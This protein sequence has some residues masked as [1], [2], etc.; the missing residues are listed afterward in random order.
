[1]EW[2]TKPRI[3]QP[4]REWA[5]PTLPETK[6]KRVLADPPL[7]LSYVLSQTASGSDPAAAEKAEG[8]Q[9]AEKR[10]RGLRNSREPQSIGIREGNA[11]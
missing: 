1:M 11:L 5:L 10:S 9:R 6:K 4:I 3:P 8:T 2:K 7:G